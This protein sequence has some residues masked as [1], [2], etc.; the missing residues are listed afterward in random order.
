MKSVLVLGSEGFI[1]SY[2]VNIGLFLGYDLTGID[3][4]ERSIIKYRYIKFS[5]LDL[6]IERFLVDNQF[7]LIINCAGSGD[8]PF[9][10]EN[11]IIDFE[12][13]SRFVICILEAIRKYCPNAR[14][15]H[16]SS[17]A[18][19]GN[20]LGLPVKESDGISPLSPYGYHKWI[21]EIICKEYS[22]LFGLS[23][24]VVRPFSV[25]GP[26]LRKQ[27]LWDVF[28]KGSTSNELILWGLGNETRDFIYV[29]DLVNALYTIDMEASELFIH[30]NLA[31]VVAVTIIEV[32]AKL[33][34]YL[35]WEKNIT[36]NGIV[37]K[38][39]PNFWQ[40]DISK[41]QKIGF[42][43]RFSEVCRNKFRSEKL[44]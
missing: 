29:E 25:Y 20:P 27:L 15:I 2:V 40:A 42:F 10:L 32:V 33:I 3:I 39:D 1:G 17:A 4:L 31:T 22:S 28:Q 41:L 26:G 35:G 11:P 43:S 36:F 19:Y 16:L 6:E 18:V 13:N 5:Q 34:H 9:S 7:D 30:Y 37:R 14:F 44:S 24:V 38:G 8:V 23:I 12:K 21:A